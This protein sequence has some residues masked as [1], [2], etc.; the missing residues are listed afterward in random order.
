M[1]YFKNFQQ[2]FAVCIIIQQFFC[3]NFFKA[4]L[5]LKYCNI[6]VVHLMVLLLVINY[7]IKISFKKEQGTLILYESQ[8]KQSL[9]WS[10][11]ILQCHNQK[12]T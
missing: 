4:F 2:K 1:T 6:L 11:I 12:L 9:P 8:N 5:K 3:N 10:H 7:P